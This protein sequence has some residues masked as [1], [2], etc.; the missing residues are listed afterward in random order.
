MSLVYQFKIS[1]QEA[2][3]IKITKDLKKRG[4]TLRVDIKNNGFLLL[5]PLLTSNNEIMAFIQKHHR[6]IIR[7]LP[8]LSAKSQKFALGAKIQFL[9]EEYTIAHN[10]EL[11]GKT[12][13]DGKKIILTGSEAYI[14]NKITQ[15]YQVELNKKAQELIS[16]YA[17]L[18]KIKVTGLTIR[19]VKSRWGSCS[20]KGRI[21]L[22]LRLVMCPN[23]IIE[24]VLVHELCHL[25]EMNHSKKFWQLVGESFPD[26]KNAEK[27]LKSEGRKIPVF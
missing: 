1:S 23:N 25:T 5:A 7:C 13:L 15:F 22:S 2:V 19:N 11:T 4:I 16:Q 12:Y 10:G 26:Y 17:D 20:S 9:G 24:Y 21:M 3:P 8:I 14:K 18:I 6:W 27:W